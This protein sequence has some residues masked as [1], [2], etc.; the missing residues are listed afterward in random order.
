LQ[1]VAVCC[2]VLQCVAVC[3]S[4]WQ[5]VAVCCSVLQCVAVCCSVPVKRHTGPATSY[6]TFLLLTLE[7]WRQRAIRI[8]TSVICSYIHLYSFW[9]KKVTSFITFLLLTWR[10]AL[11]RCHSYVHLYYL[12][13]W[14]APLFYICPSF[15]R[16]KE[17]HVCIYACV[18]ACVYARAS[19]CVCMRSRK[20]T[21]VCVPWRACV[22][23][24]MYL[25]VYIQKKS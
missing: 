3:C 10:K 16:G 25:C 19:T 22:Y 13:P 6:M 11:K 2:S 15:F 8:Y 4:V 23:R 12:H 14:Y 5:C 17:A 7:R 1:C 18:H 24:Y 9:K 21:H 20:Y